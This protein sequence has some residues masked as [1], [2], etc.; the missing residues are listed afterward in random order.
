MN[1]RAGFTKALKK[2]V[3]E[4]DNHVCQ[5]CGE[6]AVCVDHV[7]PVA[8]IPNH[9]MKN[10]VASCERCNKK[11][12]DKVFTTFEAKHAYAQ[13]FALHDE[14]QQTI[15]DLKKGRSRDELD[16]LKQARRIRREAVHRGKKNIV[17][18]RQTFGGF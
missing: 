1:D 7:V 15:R 3:L 5:Y 11:L 4:R 12:S 10:L 9:D 6:R 13:Q 2:R 17:K 18:Y 14:T 8:F 16:A